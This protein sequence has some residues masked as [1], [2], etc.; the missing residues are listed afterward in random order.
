MPLFAPVMRIVR[1]G[2]VTAARFVQLIVE[3]SK[4]LKLNFWELS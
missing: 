1:R 2:M 3:A 4:G